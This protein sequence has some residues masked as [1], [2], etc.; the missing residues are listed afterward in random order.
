MLAS[1][2]V[3]KDHPL[4]G[5][6]PGMTRYYTEDY[7]KQIG[8]SSITGN[9]QP[10]DLYIGMA[11]DAGIFGLICFLLILFVPLRDLA[12]TRKK[13]VVKRPDISYLA[14]AF[15]ISLISYMVTG[16]F[17]HLSYYRFFYLMLA[18]AVVASTFKDLQE[19]EEIKQL[20]A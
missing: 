16:L 1:A 20:E 13:W 9:Y 15:S 5:V 12:I 6:G 14:T 19:S 17:L 18:L 10:H 8:L 4:L 3:F 11:A 7:A 2:L